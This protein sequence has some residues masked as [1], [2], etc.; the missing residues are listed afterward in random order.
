[1]KRFTIVSRHNSLALAVAAAGVDLSYNERLALE[2]IRHS[3]SPYPAMVRAGIG[4]TER[5]Y[6]VRM[7]DGSLE[8][9]HVYTADGIRFAKVFSPFVSCL[10]DSALSFVAISDLEGEIY[11]TGAQFPNTK[12][13]RALAADGCAK[14]LEMAVLN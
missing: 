10:S 6:V 1:M 2:N 3:D 13:G 5:A 7:G 14:C 11:E 8:V 4:G 9:I 12:V